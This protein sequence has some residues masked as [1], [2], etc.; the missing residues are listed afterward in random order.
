MI[1]GKEAIN[2][3]IGLLGK[4]TCR[5]NKHYFETNYDVIANELINNENNVEITGIYPKNNN[6][7]TCT[8]YT[9]WV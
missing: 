9:R 7:K 1:C 6:E 5:S 3:F 4:S 8:I 2:G